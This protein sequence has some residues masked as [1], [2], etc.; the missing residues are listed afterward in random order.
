MNAAIRPGLAAE[1][2]VL[3]TD[4]MAT[5]HAGGR[6]VLAT[7][8]M[9]GLMEE[10]AQAATAP[11]LPVDHTTVGFEVSVRHRAP[12]FVGETVTIRAELLEVDRRKLLFRVVAVNARGQ[13]GEGT[14]RRTIIKLGRLEEKARLTGFGA[15]RS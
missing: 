14:H 7:P 6:G 8:A 5:T 10:T 4:Q 13:A 12:T 3:V 2:Q 11:Y 9:I 15:R 1:R